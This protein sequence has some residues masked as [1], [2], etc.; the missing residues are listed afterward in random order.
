MIE[1]AGMSLRNVDNPDGDISIEFTGLQQGEKLFEE[2]NIG[3]DISQTA[4]P[5]IMRSNEAYLRWDE[6]GSVRHIGP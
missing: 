4:H 1:L 6:L 3:R 2:L 5:R